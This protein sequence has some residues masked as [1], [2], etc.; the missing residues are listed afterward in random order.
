MTARHSSHPTLVQPN[1]SDRARLGPRTTTLLDAR[2]DQIDSWKP[3]PCVETA[4]RAIHGPDLF[5]LG[6]AICS[7]A[8]LSSCPI[9]DGALQLRS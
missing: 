4:A 6:D 9:F 3:V 7:V 1:S 8:I 5:I 2:K